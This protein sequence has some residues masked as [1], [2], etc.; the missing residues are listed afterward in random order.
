MV[1]ISGISFENALF[2]L[3]ILVTPG[4]FVGGGLKDFL[5]FHPGN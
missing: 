5:N 1:K 2:G 4:W 3:V